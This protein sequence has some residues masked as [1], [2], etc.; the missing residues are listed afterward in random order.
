[1]LDLVPAERL[2]MGIPFYNRVWR[3]TMATGEVRHHGGAMGT[4][5]TRNFFEERGVEWVWDFEIGSYFG[6][7]SGIYEGETVIFRVWLEDARSVQEKMH[8][9]YDN[10]LAGVAMWSRGFEIP[11]FW[12]VIGRY[13]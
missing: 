2:V 10:R 4:N 11:E 13:F 7:V 6:E 3:E 9:F 1:M 12:E 8:I 5:T